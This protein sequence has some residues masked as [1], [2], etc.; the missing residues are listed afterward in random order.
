V[1]LLCCGLCDNEV[2]AGGVCLSES[3]MCLALDSFWQNA[4]SGNRKTAVPDGDH[5]QR[6]SRIRISD[7]FLK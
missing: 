4:Q 1:G 6:H 5:G 2:A 7:D 3:S